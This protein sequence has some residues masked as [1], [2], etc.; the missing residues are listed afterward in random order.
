MMF[1]SVEELTSLKNLLL[2]LVIVCQ[3]LFYIG[4]FVSLALNESC[5]LE[6]NL[7][8]VYRS[9]YERLVL[10][11]LVEVPASFLGA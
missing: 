8:M 5:F 3:V 4:H 10:P 11:R 7:R 9:P 6:V 1:F 2:Y